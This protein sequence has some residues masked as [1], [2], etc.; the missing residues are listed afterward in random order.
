MPTFPSTTVG[1]CIRIQKNAK[2]VVKA[3]GLSQDWKRY[4]AFV[5]NIYPDFPQPSD[6]SRIVLFERVN[7]AIEAEQIEYLLQ[8]HAALAVAA[9]K[10]GHY[11]LYTDVA[12][13]QAEDLYLFFAWWALIYDEFCALTGLSRA[14]EIHPS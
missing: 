1:R 9:Y 8:V 4:Q 12:P 3:N 5:L 14:V 6:G 13:N 11:F 10:Y 2:K 7:A